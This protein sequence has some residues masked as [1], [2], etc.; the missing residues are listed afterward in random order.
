[1]KNMIEILTAILVFITGFYAWVTFR[2]LKANEAVLSEMRNEQEALFRPYISIA[3]TFYPDN[4]C[5]FLNIKNIGKTEAKNLS[6]KMDKDFY[7]FGKKSEGNNIKDLCAFSKPI[8][9]F[10]PGAEI[11]IYLA[12][13]FVVFGNDSDE[14]ITPKS[15]TISV[16][17]QFG[18]KSVSESTVIDLTPY[19][20]T[21]LP[22]DPIV[23]KLKD[24]NESINKK[25]A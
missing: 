4:P 5:F 25:R 18:S 20:D 2:I 13:H 6:L 1:M 7:K 23:K 19:I 15:F 24:I 22:Q 3:P 17:Y 8:D 11:L 16:Q 9:S 10:A 14:N 12:Q 21:A